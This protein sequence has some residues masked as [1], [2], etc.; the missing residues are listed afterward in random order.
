[1]ENKTLRWG[2][3]GLGKIAMKFAEALQNV[4][5]VS[6]YAV[7]SRDKEKAKTFA[8]KYMASVFYDDYLQ[9]VLDPNVDVVYV[10]TPHAFHKEHTLLCLNNTKPVLCE[11]PLAHKWIDVQE[12]ILASQKQNVFLMEAMWTRH[13]PPLKKALELIYDGQIGQVVSV[14][15][16]FGFKA[17]FNEKSRLYDMALGGGSLMD[18]GVYPL[19][20]ALTLLGKPSKVEAN[21]TLSATGADTT[22]LINLTYQN[23]VNAVLKSSIIEDT[24]REAFIKGTKGEIIFLSPWYRPTNIMLKLNNG[25]QQEFN[26]GYIGNGFEMQIK[27]VAACLASSKIESTILPHQFSLLQSEVLDEIC[28]QCNIIYP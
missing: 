26:F 14:K 13:L 17:P 15:A 23:N 20:L 4:D 25:Q 21:A 1:M 3:I 18:V 16:D 2:I 19:F 10:A 28:K 6:L 12:M 7:A 24:K 9:L 11:K 8:Q 27:E 22:C 5:G